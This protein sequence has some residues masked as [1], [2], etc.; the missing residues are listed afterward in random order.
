MGIVSLWTT[1]RR[2]L[3]AGRVRGDRGP[4]LPEREEPVPRGV[5]QEWL[6]AGARPAAPRIRMLVAVLA[7]AGSAA[8]LVQHAASGPESSSPPHPTPT[9]VVHRSPGHPPGGH[10]TVRVLVPADQPMVD[11]CAVRLRRA[12]RHQCFHT[13]DSAAAWLA[14]S[15]TPP[16]P[17]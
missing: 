16:R 4:V 17:H 6:D 15:T 8:A 1:V 3:S 10:A 13:A 9:P 12:S 11:R 5:D 7:L 2:G 14:A